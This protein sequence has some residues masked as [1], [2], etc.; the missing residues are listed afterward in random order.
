MDNQR[1]LAK[2]ITEG[3]KALKSM[4]NNEPV[5]W[6]VERTTGTKGYCDTPYV[7]LLDAT[8]STYWIENEIPEGYTVIPLY[9]HPV[10]ELTD[11]EIDK[12]LFEISGIEPAPNSVLEFAR[13]ILRKAQE[14]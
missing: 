14:K 3:F 2:E 10:K 11:G 7:T 5:A 12:V 9:T 1:S 8:K 6:M 4:R 13:A